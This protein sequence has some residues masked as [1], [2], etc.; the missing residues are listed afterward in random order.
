MNKA[1][2]AAIQ[3]SVAENFVIL[4]RLIKCFFARLYILFQLLR[5]LLYC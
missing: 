1:L 2:I 4:L 5:I 3:V